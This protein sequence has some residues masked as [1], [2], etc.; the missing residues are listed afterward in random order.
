MHKAINNINEYGMGVIIGINEQDVIDCCEEVKNKKLGIV[1]I[2][3]YNSDKQ[4]VIS[5]EKSAIK[6]AQKIAKKKGALLTKLLKVNVPS[7]CSL[8]KI[9]KPKFKQYLSKVEFNKPTLTIIHNVNAKSYNNPE[10]IKNIIIKQLYKPIKWKQTIKKMLKLGAKNII[11]CGPNKILTNINKR[12]EKNIKH[13]NTQNITEFNNI[14]NAN[15]K[16]KENDIQK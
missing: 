1:E 5:G 2:A 7:H 8:M 12:T 9:I 14:I 4:T 15:K 11:E 10:D 3:N 13:F 6:I 16:E